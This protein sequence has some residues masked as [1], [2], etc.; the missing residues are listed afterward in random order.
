[1]HDT[2]IEISPH[3]ILEPNITDIA[4]TTDVITTGTLRRDHGTHQRLLTSAA[5]LATHG[6]PIT[7]TTT[8]PTPT[9]P[10]H[11]ELPTYPFQHQTFWLENGGATAPT[12]VADIVPTDQ[13]QQS[14]PAF[15]EDSDSPWARRLAGVP[16]HEHQ[17]MV[18]RLVRATVSAVLG[19]ADADE[20][21][22]DLPL[23]DLGFDSALAVELARRL[24]RETGLTLPTTLAYEY[25]TAETLARYLL[26][27]MAAGDDEPDRPV[28]A[29]RSAG[30]DGEPIAIVAMSC[31]FPGGVDSPQ[32]LW[33]LV[34]GGVDAVS[35]LPADRGWDL[36]T[37]YDPDRA[38]T[39][40]TYTRFGG[41]LDDPAGFDAGFFNISPREAVATDPQQRVLLELTWELLERAGIVPAALRGEPVGVAIGNASSDY[42]DLLRSH[43]SDG[44]G[45]GFTGSSPSVVS[46][47]IS[48][49]FGFE[50]PA[51]TVN[52]ACSSSL[53]AIHLACQ[54][55]RNG[56]C[57][58]A[59]AGG[60]SVLGTLDAFVEFSR[61]QA[62]SV[63]GRS[64][65]FSAD[66]DGTS[67]SE[68][69]GLLLLERLEDARRAGHPVLAVVRGTAINQDGASNG[70]TAP[71]GAAQQ[72][73]IRQALAAAGL[74]PHDVDLLEA[75]GTGTVLG[76]PIE[77]RALLATYGR[78]RPADRPLWLGSLKSNFGH[79]QSAAGVG[80]V[81]K[82]VEAMRH[83]VLPKTLHADEPNPHVDWSSGTVALLTEARP[84]SELERPRRAGISSFGASGTNAHV[85]VEYDHLAGAE[86]GAES[87]AGTEEAA[88]A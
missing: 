61:Q 13:V 38:R 48:Y 88:A 19:Y 1:G 30:P 2:F 71:N 26:A 46:G 54:A 40:T 80:G 7:W 36:D 50:G 74:G 59:V 81:I 73:V 82:A 16:A 10:H 47:R 44:D 24:G 58:L 25:P 28:L 76:D 22:E 5:H 14:E 9:P 68:G 79:A 8:L 78:D 43:G 60:A 34:E 27:H 20:I 21:P 77:A 4:D 29:R 72:R 17:S 52:T 69:A 70:L 85:I 15:S 86:A 87:G 45:Y 35:E 6:T 51:V 53:V 33:R 32:A 11:T 41:F 57:T 66:A 62:L 31:R 83:G 55:L 64:K 56:E 23:K 12:A 42:L 84:W 49:T 18:S 37:L 63:D 75:H 65:A 39:G 67:W 3:P